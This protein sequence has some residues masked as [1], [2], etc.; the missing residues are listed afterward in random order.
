MRAAAAITSITMK[1]GTSLRPDAVRRPLVR[2][3]SVVSG[4]VICYFVTFITCRGGALRSCQQPRDS[5]KFGKTVRF[6]LHIRREHPPCPRLALFAR[7][8]GHSSYQT[9]CQS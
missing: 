1:G 7:L 8:L 4:I 6:C 3:L 5:G 9:R 2:S